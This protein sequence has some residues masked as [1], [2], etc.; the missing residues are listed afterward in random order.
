MFFLIFVNKSKT[1]TKMKRVVIIF[2]EM[3]Y[4]GF[5]MSYR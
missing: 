1:K 4:F 2:M 3:T 5:F